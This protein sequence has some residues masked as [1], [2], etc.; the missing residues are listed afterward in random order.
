MLISLKGALYLFGASLFKIFFAFI[1]R[2]IWA[3]KPS[4]VQE[5]IVEEHRNIFVGG[6][7][8]TTTMIGEFYWNFGII[9]VAIAMAVI[10]YICNKIDF[11]NLNKT[12]GS[13]QFMLRGY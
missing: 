4:G 7:S 13:F 5:L 9:G 11:N 8:Q 2:Q 6:T 12:K 1:P 3:D 10:G